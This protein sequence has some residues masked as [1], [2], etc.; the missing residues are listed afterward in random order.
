MASNTWDGC[1]LPEEQAEPED[2]AIPQGRSRSLRSLPSGR[3]RKQRVSAGASRLGEHNASGVC[4]QAALKMVS[5]TFETNGVAVESADG[6]PHGRAKPRDSGNVFR[7]RPMPRSWPPPRN[8]GSS[9]AILARTSACALGRQSCAPKAS[10]DRH[11]S[12]EVKR[13]FPR[14]GLRRHVA[15]RRGM[16]ISPASATGCTARFRCWPA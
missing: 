5:Q 14:P 8:T 15:I 7:A 6:G 2:T 16:D 4:R 9:P 12:L 10:P 13:Y 1:T 3:N 11:S